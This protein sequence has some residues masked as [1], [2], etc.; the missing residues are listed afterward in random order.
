M[1][2]LPVGGEE[3]LLWP[4]TVI[5]SLAFCVAALSVVG[6]LALVFDTVP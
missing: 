6:L 3:K 5:V 2:K 4:Q 1:T